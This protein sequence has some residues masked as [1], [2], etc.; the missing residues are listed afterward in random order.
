MAPLQRFGTWVAIGAIV[1]HAL[2]VLSPGWVVTFQQQRARDFA[3]YY[4]AV[5]VGHDHGDPYDTVQLNAAARADGVRNGVHP[6]LYAPPFLLA[7][8]WVR[9]FDL[10]EAY[11]L[12][13]WLDELCAIAAG[14]ALWRWWRPL[15]W[16]VGPLIAVV[17]ALMTAIPNNHAMGQANFPGLLLAIGGLWQTDR[18]RPKLGG[19]LMGAACMLKMSP[20]LFVVYWLV[21]REWT[22]VGAAVATGAALSVLS[23]PF[24]GPAVQWGFY[25]EVLPTFSNGLYNGLG[26]SIGLF[27]NHSLPNVLDAIAPHPSNVLSPAAQWAASILNAA[28]LALLAWAFW[29]RD[30]GTGTR[31][32]APPDPLRRAAQASCYGV[33]LLLMPVYTYEHHLVFAIPAMVVSILAVAQGR[34][35][36]GWAAPIGLAVAVLL[37]DL[38]GLKAMAEGVPPALLAV[39]AV[40]REAKFGALVLLLASTERIG[41]VPAPAPLASPSPGRLGVSPGGPTPG[42]A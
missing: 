34:L 35:R 18:G 31:R 4:Y 7:A 15:G 39:G 11:H 14:I 27:G 33:L 32:G 25:T 8:S 28:L 6:F 9:G 10:G 5:Q 38:Q 19:A 1:W 21:R 2:S 13:F 37:F 12:W 22:A 16:E 36:A 20:A 29:P 30:A 23:L 24:A 17:M 26:I 41:H 40:L 3:T 42:S